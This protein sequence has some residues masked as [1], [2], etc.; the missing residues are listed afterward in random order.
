MGKIKWIEIHGF[1]AFGAEAQRL[2]FDGD[3][4]LIWGPNSQG[5]TSISEA[6]EF[7]FT[8]DIVRRSFIGSARAE[9]SDSLKNVYLPEDTEV[10]VKAGIEDNDEI[11]REV[12]RTLLSDYSP[13]GD[14][15]SKLTID[16]TEVQDLESIGIVLSSPPL[17]APILMQHTLR[18]VLSAPPQERVDYFK[19]LMDIT[20]IEYL[21]DEIA[22]LAQLPD[23]STLAHVEMLNRI[24]INEELRTIR[25][26]ILEKGA[27]INLLEALLNQCMQ[28]SLK[29]LGVGEEDLPDTL[30]RGYKEL[31]TFLKKKRE[32]AFPF[33]E[34]ALGI[35]TPNTNLSIED[36][37]YK[38]FSK[39]VEDI[40][41]EVL[42]L[43]KI[44]RAA[45]EIPE[46]QSSKDAVDCPL[47]G[48]EQALTADR[49]SEIRKQVES[50][51][52]FNE[53]QKTS[54][55]QIEATAAAIRNAKRGLDSV[56]PQAISWDKET[57][58]KH[59][60]TV[61]D[62]IGEGAKDSYAKVSEYLQ[63]F[64]KE[65]A[66]INEKYE[67]LTKLIDDAKSKIE[68]SEAINIESMQTLVGEFNKLG[69]NLIGK[70]EEYTALLEKVTLPL[71]AEIDRA[72]H[73]DTYQE[74]IELVK[75]RGELSSEI[76][77]FT[78]AKKVREEIEKAV[79]DIDRAKAQ[80]FDAKFKDMSDEI[81]HWWSMIRRNQPVVFGGV[82][83]RGTGR[84]FIDFKA[85]FLKDDQPT[86]IERDAV[87]VFSDSQLNC[88]GLS[89]FFA[90]CCRGSNKFVL[91]DDPVVACDEE[92]RATFARFVIDELLSKGMQV[93]ITTYDTLFKKLILDYHQHRN[94]DIFISTMPDP[95]GVVVDKA[96]DTLDQMLSGARPFLKNQ[97]PE[98]R[99]TG[100]ERLRDTAERLCKEIIVKKRREQGEDCNIIQYEKKNLGEL[101]PL[102]EPYLTDASHPGKFRA[103]GTILNPGSHD[104]IVPDSEALG[105][106][107]G[108]IKKFKKDYL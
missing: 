58:D 6:F 69:E 50:T 36:E 35:A 42:R 49:I 97:V 39:L 57:I 79:E 75:A 9:F 59:R 18:Y 60:Q 68:D 52:K 4:H 56:L 99:K 34:L 33:A 1:R 7:L 82:K 77:R 73:A 24:A 100:A 27:D 92:H 104:T 28:V 37:L 72:E 29:A 80:V 94:L 53:I 31:E 64:E 90:R 101:I 63:A 45:L 8:G 81:E 46:I 88:L 2:D 47:C 16:G 21:R 61:V 40:E 107:F 3:L 15:A 44:F 62:L 17:S 55:S 67:K 26:E 96:S 95:N 48:T 74:L 98:I 83:R 23:T 19:A 11:E 106:A 43:V 71:Q 14:C 86:G 25:Q 38:N 13:Q 70:K 102:V 12:C 32:A 105:V 103:L 5:K 108:D 20:D 91:L 84:R 54:L 41:K 66:N 22:S 89:A 85:A 10:Y 65:R 78:A 51:V 93:I 30:D 76:K 87:G